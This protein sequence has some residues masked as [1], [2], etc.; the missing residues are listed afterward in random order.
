MIALRERNFRLYWLG[1]AASNIGNWA[2]V[3][4]IG[5]FVLQITGTPLALGFL[6]LAQSVPLF[7]LSLVGGV[8]AD[9][10]PRLQILFVTQSAALVLALVLAWLA[11]LGKPPLWSLLL[12]AALAASVTSIDNPTRQAFLSDLVGKEIL[13]NAVALNATVYNGAAVI[14]PSLAGLLLIRVGAVGCFL[15]N[16]VSF[17]PVLVALFIIAWNVAL[18][19]VSLQQQKRKEPS[20]FIGFGSLRSEHAI[21]AVLAIAS[22]TSLLGRPYLL[23][24]PA[25]ARTVQHVGAVELG[26]MVAASGT[27]SLLGSLL[28]ASRRFLK[29][30]EYMLL[31]CGV[32]FGLALVFFALATSYVLAV[33][34][35]VLC[36]AGATMTMTVA[37]TL[38]QTYAHAGMRGRVMSLYTLIAAGLTPLGTLLVSAIA[39]WLRLSGATVVMGVGVVVA[40]VAGYRFLRIE[41]T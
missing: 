1:Q 20:P 16:A 35:L 5:W 27:G 8:L 21:L 18:R 24:M 34:V 28:L 15:L 4:A 10:F 41:T 3:V 37:N 26:V 39:T 14:G 23:L 13:L 36:G 6:G 17:L 30:L 25:F 38:L 22:A 29:R 40:V 32:G 9:R 2:Q 7:A 33:C 12:V 19:P 31:I 11:S